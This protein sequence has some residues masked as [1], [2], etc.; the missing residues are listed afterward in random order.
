MVAGPGLWSDQ[1][2]LNRGPRGSTGV[3]RYE[4]RGLPGWPTPLSAGVM[5]AWVYK[6]LCLW[7]GRGFLGLGCCR[8]CGCGVFCGA[9]LRVWGAGVGVWSLPGVASGS[10]GGCW[11]VEVLL[12]TAL[13]MVSV[14]AMPGSRGG[15]SGGGAGARGGGWSR[16]LHGAWV[17]CLHLELF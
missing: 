10:F 14:S 6:F 12:G 7:W 8:L 17:S 2:S 11:G 5:L 9:V 3:A 15:V 16:T 1:R 4:P 13:W